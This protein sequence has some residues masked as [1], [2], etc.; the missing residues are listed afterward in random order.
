MIDLDALLTELPDVSEVEITRW[1]SRGWVRPANGDAPWHFADID[2]ARVRLIRDLR[3]D[4]AIGD[5]ALPVVLSLL[6][7]V[8]ALRGQIRRISDALAVLDEPARRALLDRL[9]G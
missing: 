5:E 8:Y 1:V 4:M 6:D 3:H 2:I 7:Q 9:Q